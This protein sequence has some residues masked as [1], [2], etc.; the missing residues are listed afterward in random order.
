MATAVSIWQAKTARDAQREAE[1]D[2]DRANTAQTDAEGA[3][4]HA[5]MEAAVATAISDF[6]Q[7]DLL[8]E[9]DT[10]VQRDEALPPERNLTVKEALDRAAAK[11]GK[12][13]QDQPLVEAAIR[14]TIGVAYRNVGE[15]RLA[16]PHLERS[17]ALRKA[18]LGPAHRDT[19]SSVQRLAEA[20]RYVSWH[21]HAITLYQQVLEDREA[22]LG[23]DHPETLACVG[24]LA[25]AYEYAGQLETSV[26]L[27]EQLVEKCRTLLGPTHSSTLGNMHRL[28][29]NYAHMDRL[30]ESIALHD[31]VLELRKSVVDPEQDLLIFWIHT[32]AWVCQWTGDLDR[33][34]RLLREVLDHDR[35][36][37]ESRI[38]PNGMATRLA[39]LALNLLLQGRPDEA[40]PL[41]REAVGLNQIEGHHRFYSVSVLG[42]VLLGQKKYAEG[43]PLLLQGYQGLKQ[44]EAVH[45]AVRRWRKQV[46]EWVV[47]LYDATGQPEK[48]R[49]W[50]EK[51]LSS[52]RRE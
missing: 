14:M 19:I 26:R 52:A 40:E 50:R 24:H 15:Y 20:Y 27:L 18:H 16:V 46:G 1:A 35:R 31:K 7:R 30:T 38:R 41:A 4:Q 28:A 42:A 47:R 12:R 17:V 51:L 49:M 34:D 23:P 29:W 36:Q 2:R 13:F 39:S 43:E 37:D 45:P 48:A 22:R 8:Q 44:N 3:K 5:A 33:A 11:I 32:L 6:L 25:I 9:V 10:Y 21:S